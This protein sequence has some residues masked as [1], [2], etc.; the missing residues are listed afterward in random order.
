MD[1]ILAPERD[2]K[3]SLEVRG[4][5]LRFLGPASALSQHNFEGEPG[6][7]VFHMHVCGCKSGC[8]YKDM[9]PCLGI[10]VIYHFV[11][12]FYAKLLTVSIVRIGVQVTE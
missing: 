5:R 1:A 2:M 12:K 8:V 9:F 7:I 6:R 10:G 4:W 11:R 3:G